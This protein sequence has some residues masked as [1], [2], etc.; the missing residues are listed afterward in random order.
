MIEGD[1]SF[2]A[3]LYAEQVY[4]ADWRDKVSQEATK[5]GAEPD[6]KLPQFLLNDAAFDYGDCKAFVKS[7]YEDGGWKAVNAAFVDPP[8]TTEQILHLDKYKSHELANTGPPP[9]LSTRL[10]DWQ[11]ID[12]SQFG[13]FDVF[14]YAVSLTGDA[15]AAVVAAAGWG[16][17]WSSAYRNKSDPSRVIVQLS[18]GWDTQQD[19][20]E[21]AVVYDRI[22][23]SLGATVQPVGAKGNVRW[24]A[25]GQFGA[26]SLIENTSRIE[27]RIASDE[28]GLKDA[29]AD[30]KDFQ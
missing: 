28:A 27:M 9:D 10:T 13:E 5:G 16:S 15:S 19:L 3:D 8:D 1:A 18:F 17:G 21:F 30:W 23:Q 20:L 22:L 29:I 2:T 24:S 6:S 12:S 11:L 7:L 14:N 26:A 4:G 25:N